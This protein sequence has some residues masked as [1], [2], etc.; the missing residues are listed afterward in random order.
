MRFQHSTILV[1][2]GAGFIGSAV[3]RHLLDDTDAF[4]VNID[5]LT[6]A[7][8][9]NSIPQAMTSSH[10][11]FA[12]A[13]I[14]DGPALRTLFEQFRPRYIMNLAA[15][16][17]VDRSI[18]GPKAFIQTNVVGTFTLL[19]EALRFWRG[20]D[21]TAQE[22]FRFHHVSTD[23]VYGSLGSEG[24]FSETT[25]YAPRSP[26]S[27]SKASSDHLVRSW[28]ETYGLPVLVTNCTNNYGPY[29]FPEK[30]IPHII[31]RALA[32]QSLPIY[33]DGRNIRDWL[34]VEDHARALT[35]VVEHGAIGETYNIGGGNER[36]N[37]EVV[38][39]IC[40]LLDEMQPSIH[41]PRDRLITFVADRP[42]HDRRYGID[43][44]KIKRQLGWKPTHDFESGLAKTV[45]WYVENRAW[46]EALL[47]R[48]Y[49]GERLG[50]PRQQHSVT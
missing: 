20:L 43:A 29:H 49:R 34:Y 27:A 4:V 50:L 32:E 47:D 11:R 28:H 3:I 46:W 18:D 16:S 24:L 36:M 37:V 22:H 45:R 5:K 23:E 8:N 40:R 35:L 15:E 7:S 6:Y 25:P 19:Q 48:G 13:D 12:R 17:H 9:L 44:T 26:Y 1:T 42:G 39:S 33:G 14:C 30:L 21:R 38:K 10:Y 41:G 2:G 31:I